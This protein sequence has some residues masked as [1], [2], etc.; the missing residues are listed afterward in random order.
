M[1]MDLRLTYAH[2]E[3]AV[4]L[5]G[6]LNQKHKV[7]LGGNM[8]DKIIV[9][10]HDIAGLVRRLRRFKFEM[11]KS[12]S[13]NLTEVTAHDKLRLISYLQAFKAY[14]AWMLSQPDLDL[15]ESSPKGI[16][17]EEMVL[18]PQPE[19]ESIVDILNLLNLIEI[20]L[21][22][23]VSGRRP[24]GLVIHDSL[25][26]DALVLKLD[27]FISDYLPQTPLDLPESSPEKLLTG[28]GKIGV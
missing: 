20:E 21:V 10:N 25:R 22:N 4:F 2:N 28:P 15:P 6:L 7:P 9:Y 1:L 23:G 5:R 19:N 26:I 3:L 14:K 8:A 13:S 16:E 12:V 17:L 24:S 27:K 11:H 18:L